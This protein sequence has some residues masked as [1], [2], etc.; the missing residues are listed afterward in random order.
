[1]PVW[2]VIIF[3][4]LR[5]VLHAWNTDTS[6]CMHASYDCVLP[7]DFMILLVP[8]GLLC[9]AMSCHWQYAI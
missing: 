7:I 8:T 6:A 2:G 3:I 1:M 4:A 5:R 9:H